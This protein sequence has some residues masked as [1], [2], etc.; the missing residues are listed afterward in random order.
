MRKLLSTVAA[1][2]IL[3]TSVSVV[4][5]DGLY[6]GGS[7]TGYY[8][9]SERVIDGAD[10]SFVG[11]IN[12]GHR[13]GQWAIEGGF[14]R[15]I[16]GDDLDVSKVDLLYYLGGVKP[17]WTPYLVGSLSYF[18]RD[19]N[20][21][22]RGESHTW[23][24]GA[25]IGVST[26]LSD[27]WEFRTDVRA[28]QKIH[29]GRDATTDAAL[30]FAANYYFNPPTAAV[31]EP[32]PAPAP[33]PQQAEPQTRTITVR[34]NVEFEFDKAVVR[35]IYGDEIQGVAN[36]MKAHQD[37]QLVLEGHTDSIGTDAYNQDL[38]ERRV[39]AV[40]AKIVQDYGI[41]PSRISTVGYG[42]SRPIADNNTEE[43]RARNRRV[44]GELSFKEV[45][46]D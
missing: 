35:N 13:N 39:A 17:G 22:Q 43:G 32:A 6:L 11:G 23:Q 20:N 24:A 8:L 46:A 27:H 28:L 21:L 18:D 16:A 12:L 5:S 38:S 42:E 1:A 4:A 34:L 31:A 26:M 33:A 44:I 2:A 10:K 40:K 25:G 9:D 36:A 14:G 15:D 37:I 41:N 3:A 7:A 29:S 19:S 45:V 30:T